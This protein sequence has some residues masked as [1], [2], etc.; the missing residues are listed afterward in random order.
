MA[1]ARGKAEGYSKKLSN[2]EAEAEECLKIR[3]SR[4]N[5]EKDTSLF[6]R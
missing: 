3:L 5:F 2:Q 1:D 4:G 6:T